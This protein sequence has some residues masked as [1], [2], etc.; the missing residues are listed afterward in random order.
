MSL[1]SA[2]SPATPAPSL[3]SSASPATP[4]SRPTMFGPGAVHQLLR[5][6]GYLL[7]ALPV[8]I[9]SFTVLV[10]GLSLAAGLLITVIGIPVAAA[11]LVVAEWFGRLD[12][13]RLAARGTALG[14]V[15][16]APVRGRG[17]R[18]MLR[19]LADPL[20]WAA[21]V[22]GIGAMVLSIVTWS[23]AVTWWAGTLAGL[24]FWF[25]SPWVPSPDSNTTLPELLGLPMTESFLNL[26]LGLVLAVTLIPVLRGCVH[27]HVVWAS[28]LL[29]GASRRALAAQV[30]DLTARRSAAAAA[31]EQSLRRL[32][33]D[34]HDGPQQRLVRLGMDLSVAERR[35]QDDPEAAR[36]LLVAARTQ[37][38]ETLAEL[39]ALSR[40]IAPPVLADRGL[41]AALSAVAA[42]ATVPVAVDVDL[43]GDTRPASSVENAA[44]F[45]VCEA[46]S[47]TAKHAAAA[48]AVVRVRH[49]PADASAAEGLVVEV[50]DDGVGGAAAAK[51]HGLA[52]LADRVEG[53][54]GALVVD[55]PPG[56]PT[57]VVATLPWT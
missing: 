45:V 48:A 27:L 13:A 50:L 16:Y 3:P 49:V 34:I 19:L 32:E 17:L 20:R 53:L 9:L 22:H 52:G 42:R 54:G 51:G 7:P 38:A 1:P 12:R 41:A 36:E 6:T 15:Q 44:Y 46:L 37:A 57:R 35:L 11:T 28:L 2:G 21:V 14:P 47:N 5:D 4:L 39:R 8:A 30:E 18:G 33:R 24:T 25:W 55:S 26:L 56:G 29:T 10:T 40:G 31:E 23:I 43:P